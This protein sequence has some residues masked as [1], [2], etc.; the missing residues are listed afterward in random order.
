MCSKTAWFRAQ[1]SAYRS[2]AASPPSISL[3]VAHARKQ[4]S[5][6][7]GCIKAPMPDL[8][9]HS[10]LQ[11]TLRRTWPE[12]CR[13]STYLAESSSSWELRAGRT[14]PTVI[15]LLRLQTALKI[16]A[17]TRPRPLKLIYRSQPVGPQRGKDDRREY[18][19]GK[20][21]HGG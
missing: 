19:G 16:G 6:D 13:W 17:K 7:A 2:V 5:I 10:H 14:G 1:N 4:S 12:V 9:Q 20:V 3:F 18:V 15:A 11:R 8:E 21:L